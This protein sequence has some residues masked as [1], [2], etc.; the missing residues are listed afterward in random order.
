MSRA[1]SNH[2]PSFHA[3]LHCV[4]TEDDADQGFCCQDDE[5]DYEAAEA[6]A[7]RA[8]QLMEAAFGEGNPRSATAY[9]TLA[10]ILK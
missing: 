1:T 10:S 6:S 8:V 3:T 5:K 7:R 2:K 9:G 4:E